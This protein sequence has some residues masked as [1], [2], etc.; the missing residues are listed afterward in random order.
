MF[1]NRHNNGFFRVW[2]KENMAFA[3]LVHSSDPDKVDFEWM[4]EHVV[5]KDMHILGE[6]DDEKILFYSFGDSQLMIYD[7]QK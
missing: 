1:S 2:Q 5:K 6:I 4:T 7:L 3:K